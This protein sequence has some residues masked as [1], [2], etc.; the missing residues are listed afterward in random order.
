M[1][2][3]EFQGFTDRQLQNVR[4]GI[5]LV[6]DLKRRFIEAFALTF[7]ATHKDIREE[8]HFDFAHAISLARLASASLHI[9]GESAG[10]VALHARF[11]KFREE[12][13]DLVEDFDVGRGI[14][15][16]RA[17]DGA[18][19][20]VDDFIELAEPGDRPMLPDSSGRSV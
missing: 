13:S 2:G 4:D 14:A 8:M 7:L 11:R 16:W 10:L 1:M 6:Q 15:S 19:V 3:E 18:L 20:D 12:A 9:E 5:S 17:A